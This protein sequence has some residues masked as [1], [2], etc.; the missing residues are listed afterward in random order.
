MIS[1]I[2][3]LEKRVI[4]TLAR[5]L[6]VDK[7]SIAPT[8][9]IA[10]DLGADSLASIELIMALE[11]EFGVAIGD[12][13]VEKLVTVQHAIDYLQRALAAKT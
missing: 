5:Q 9:S 3:T 10:K 13:H 7:D 12:E 11:H 2:E 6:R 8:M 1:E 4:A